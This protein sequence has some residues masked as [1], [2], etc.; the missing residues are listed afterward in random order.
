MD[1]QV[2]TMSPHDPR[3]LRE[4][5]DRAA[6]LAHEHGLRSVVV[7][8]TGFDG[9]PTFQEVVD[10]I[11]SAL[12]VDDTVYRMTRDRV[13]LL[14]TDVNAEQATSVLQRLIGEYRER[15]PR[16]SDPS[17]GFGTFEVG[18]DTGEVSVKRILP[19]LFATPRAH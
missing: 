9:D 8:L 19:A 4:M 12:R 1:T 10:Y 7:G 13:V 14:L 15:F 6:L 18:P 16:L 3:R 2:Q 5:M 11:E 17:V